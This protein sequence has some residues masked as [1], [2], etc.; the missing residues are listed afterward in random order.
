MKTGA[1]NG[2]STPD[3]S[4]PWAPLRDP[5]FLRLWSVWLIANLCMWM[6]DVAAAWL[7]TSL[8][9]SKLMVAMIQTC[10]TLPVFLL[11]LPG[12][13]V[14]DVVDRHRGLLVAQA[15]SAAAAAVLAATALGGQ[16][17]AP[18]LLG[19]TFLASI[20]TAL[21]WPVYSALVPDVVGREALPAA[22][23]LGGMAVNASRVLGPLAAGLVIG[24]AS[25]AWV[26][27]LTTA[28][29]L[30]S[31]ALLWRPP[32]AHA[33]RPAQTSQG[34]LAAMAA[35]LAF[36]RRNR[37]FQAVLLWS[38]CF[39]LCATSLLGL[40]PLV[41]RGRGAGSAQLYTLL[42]ACLGSGA[43]GVGF[44]LHHARRRWSVQAIVSAG[45]ALLSACVACMAFDGPAW[46]S[47]TVMFLAGAAWLAV[48][49]TLSIAAQL[50]LPPALRARG[51]SIFLMA[52][53]AGG[54]AGAAL[55]GTVAEGLGLRAALL[56]LAATG[57]AV[58]AVLGR[59]CRLG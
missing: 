50:A 33:P 36:A 18:L 46:R 22:I 26:F 7:M 23:V 41:A 53:M 48:G 6:G 42:F 15:W 5:G 44:V 45:T 13:A 35:G 39:F 30:A 28:L 4:T 27:V 19:L 25:G 14:A 11:A 8:T 24:L 29:S 56:T 21:R 57:F 9:S 49:N 10:T 38:F 31:I 37:P 51:L 43:V 17:S 3:P 55:F 59:R 52:V 12:G 54:A 16:L 40:L 47:G 1:P 2:E 34:L 20:A 32:P 58:A